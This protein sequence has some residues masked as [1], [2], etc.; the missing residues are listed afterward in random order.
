MSVE[1]SNPAEELVN[2]FTGQTIR[3]LEES[4]ELLV[5]DSTYLPGAAP[6]PA[7][8]H[9]SQEEIFTVLA[10]GV[11][12]SVGGEERI[13]REGDVL[14][15]AAG[16]PHEFGGL[17]EEGGTIRWEVRP[18]L[19]TREFFTALFAALQAAADEQAGR[20]PTAGADFDV[21]DYEDVF[22]IA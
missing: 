9:P 21:G 1:E 15:I 10:G 11:R 6:A 4:E 13:L 3:F 5:M 2:P 7:H 19:R 12:A 8:L 17:A 22:R 18:A 20:T 14:V 16:T